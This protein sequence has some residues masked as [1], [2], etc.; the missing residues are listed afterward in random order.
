MKKAKFLTPVVTVF[1]EN[2]T[3][4]IKS[5]EKLWDYL[6]EGGIDG[7]VLLGSTGEFFF[8]NMG[9][10]KALISLAT[11][12][13][14]KRTKLYIGTACTSIDDTI[15][16]SN[17]ALAKGADAVMII[18]PYYFNLSNES[19]EFYFNKLASS[20]EGNIYL[21]NFP[22]RT[23]YDLNVETTLKILR[24]NKNII[25]YK[26]TVSEM[27]HTRNLLTKI[28][29]EFPKFE[30][31]CG[32]DENFIQNVLSG[33]VGCI[34]GLSNLFPKLFSQWR[35]AINEKNFFEIERIQNIVNKLMDLYTIGTPFIPTMKRAMKLKGIIDKDYSLEP[36]LE[37]TKEE[38][39]IIKSVIEISMTEEKY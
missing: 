10:K 39:E 28:L 12:Y 30:I 34:G 38:E 19:I 1:N 22:D 14:N 2:R 23:G 7:I 11:E 33:G 9:E 17:F 5:N 31:F 15:E 8:M 3:L 16:L 29:K 27:G 24:K 18:G 25:G 36:F 35:I 26:D 20:I 13:I 6:I 32:F 37:S 21:Y 4:D